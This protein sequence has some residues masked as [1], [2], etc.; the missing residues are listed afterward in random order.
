MYCMD[1]HGGFTADLP[2]LADAKEDLVGCC[3]P[4]LAP[5]SGLGQEHSDCLTKGDLKPAKNR[6]EGF[7]FSSSVSKQKANLLQTLWS[8]SKQ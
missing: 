8:R 2:G 4:E 1:L 5:M 7:I 6:A 3:E